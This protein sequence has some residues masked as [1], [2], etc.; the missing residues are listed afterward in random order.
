[1]K[2]INR[3]LRKHQKRITAVCLCLILIMYTSS[4]V[5]ASRKTV[6]ISS[7][8]MQKQVV[9]FG[10]ATTA[11]ALLQASV[12]LNSDEQLSKSLDSQVSNNETIYISKLDASTE[13][14]IVAS[15][16]EE[17]AEDTTSDIQTNVSESAAAVSA[18][19]EKTQT[20][21]KPATSTAK[22]ETTVKEETTD[23]GESSDDGNVIQTSAGLLNYMKKI[24]V[25]A[26][27]Y[28][29]TSCYPYDGT[30][31]ADGSSPLE[32]HT[33]AASSEYAFGTNVY[34]P[35]FDDAPNNGVFE[36]EDR[37]GAITGNRID[38]FYTSNQAALNFGRRTL[39]IYILE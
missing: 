22:E 17:P 15:A 7:D 10:R 5:Y 11:D 26:T 14:D 33:I 24:E 21:T 13:T 9:L 32:Y 31:T 8:E 39:T 4:F 34:I 12:T 36:V 29:P 16:T 23:N 20:D 35:Y 6:T 25:V 37:G 18:A 2:K 1:M 28:D 19:V 38:I 30:T 27:A 3:H